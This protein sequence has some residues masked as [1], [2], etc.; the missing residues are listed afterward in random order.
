[1][2]NAIV[3]IRKIQA[4]TDKVAFASSSNPLF[5]HDQARN[6]KKNNQSIMVTIG[7]VY[8]KLLSFCLGRILW[9]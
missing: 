6:G 3:P 1:M 8:L 2:V 4:I 5:I 7:I 9:I